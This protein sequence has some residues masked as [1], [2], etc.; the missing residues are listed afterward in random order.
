MLTTFVLGQ[1]AE[2]GASNAPGMQRRWDFGLG[3]QKLS[4]EHSSGDDELP[5]SVL[6]GINIWAQHAWTLPLSEGWSLRSTA[7]FGT[8]RYYRRLIWFLYASPAV[9]PQ[10]A[11]CAQARAGVLVGY[12]YDQELL[13]G[14]LLTVYSEVDLG[15]NWGLLGGFTATRFNV[16]KD[17]GVKVNSQELELGFIKK[18]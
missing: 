18:W 11:F 7:R 13:H 4:L 6:W 3:L 5:A 1:S 15:E 9:G 10:Y 14:A 2:G 16:P 8:S 17:S 12:R